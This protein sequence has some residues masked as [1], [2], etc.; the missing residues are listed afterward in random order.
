VVIF[1]SA[2]AIPS[3]AWECMHPMTGSKD[4]LVK[5]KALWEAYNYTPI[6]GGDN[7]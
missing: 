7:R 4:T 2:N 6:T 1:A 5:I 3:S